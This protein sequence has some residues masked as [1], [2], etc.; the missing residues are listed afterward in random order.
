[1][2]FAAAFR[3][4]TIGLDIGSSAVRAVGLRRTRSGWSLTAAA[5]APFPLT[6][7]DGTA[8][9]AAVTAEVIR[10]ALDGLRMPKAR[11]A[12]ALSGHVIVKRLSLPA[13]TA[14]EL[15]EAI[16]WEAEQYIRSTRRRADRLPGRERR[17]QSAAT[18]GDCWSRRKDRIEDRG[19][20]AHRAPDRGA[21]CQAFASRTPA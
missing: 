21:R 8:P 18:M 19:G 2:S 11:V 9:S 20:Q 15:A 17:R 3:A 1:M 7:G 5:D 6:D 12:A 4:S 16:P 10:Q 13:M 14:A